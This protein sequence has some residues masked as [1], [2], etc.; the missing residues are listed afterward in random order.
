MTRQ[1]CFNGE[2]NFE[3]ESF[4]LLDEP[5]KNRKS[6]L[7]N[8]V[9]Y[10]IGG[11]AIAGILL[12]FFLFK[13]CQS[14]VCKKSQ[15]EEQSEQDSP[16][17]VDPATLP[18]SQGCN[19]DPLN[20]IDVH[21]LPTIPP[22]GVK[23]NMPIYVDPDTVVSSREKLRENRGEVNQAFGNVQA[24]KPPEDDNRVYQAPQATR[25]ETR[26]KTQAE[27]RVETR[28]E[29]QAEEDAE[30]EIEDDQ[31]EEKIQANSGSEASETNVPFTQ[32]KPRANTEP[33]MGY[34]DLDSSDEIEENFYHSLHTASKGESKTI[35][36]VNE[37]VQSSS[38][39]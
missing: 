6:F 11:S 28:A 27:T 10:I 29:T 9:W 22:G 15:Q 24:E 5:G 12:G 30:S 26:V 14:G 20:Y 35:Y 31:E 17:Y 39:R 25:A 1:S 23:E 32:R 4:H 7:Q 38:F 33:M 3:N 2:R 19:K 13:V 34:Q 18:M 21:V 16:V 36:Y 37:K 8:Y